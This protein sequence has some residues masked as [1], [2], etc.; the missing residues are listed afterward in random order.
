LLRTLKEI[1]PN[2]LRQRLKR[3]FFHQ[4][5][6]QS[7]LQNLRR[8]GLQPSG[9][10]DVG[11]FEGSW[12]RQWWRIWPHAPVWLFEPLPTH[13]KELE[14]LA[15]SH[16]GSRIIPKAVS[17]R[18]GPCHFS[19][20]A[21][22]SQIVDRPVAGDVVEIDCTTLDA[23]LAD[24]AFTPNLV[25]IDVQGRELAVLTGAEKVLAHVEV[26]ILEVSVLRIGDVPIF[27][28]VDRFLEKKGYRIYDLLPQYYRPRDGALWQIDAFYVREE[29]QLISS[30]DW[31]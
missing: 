11:A 7:R 26:I 21:T 19:L 18:L 24:Q 17:D 30:R 10:L 25:K 15:Q 8:A 13:Q 22:N 6:M 31:A 2:D 28:E 4:Q 20:E 1:L 9:A 14:A 12:A 27:R 23:T 16:P 3:R 5:D 29:S